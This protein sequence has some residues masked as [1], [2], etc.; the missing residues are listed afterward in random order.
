[1]PH[2]ADPAAD[3]LKSRKCN[4]HRP[5]EFVRSTLAIRGVRIRSQAASFLISPEFA[6]RSGWTLTP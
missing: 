6:F 5:E 3:V 4:A 1:M 2:V